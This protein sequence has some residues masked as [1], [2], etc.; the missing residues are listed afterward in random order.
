[1]ELNKGI[2]EFNEVKILPHMTQSEFE[3]LFPKGTFRINESPMYPDTVFYTNVASIKLDDILVR[4]NV[5]FRERKI[6]RIEAICIEDH[7][8]NPVSKWSSKK[9]DEHREFHKKWLSDRL[10]KPTSEDEWVTIYSFDW[11]TISSESNPRDPT[12]AIVF[13]YGVEK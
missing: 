12:L 9:Y 11:G 10:G 2:L 3:A 1:M 13:M 6:Q 8:R 7:L 5:Y 4:V